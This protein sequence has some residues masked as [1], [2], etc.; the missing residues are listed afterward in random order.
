MM[1]MLSISGVRWI[2]SRY[3]CWNSLIDQAVHFSIWSII[4]TVTT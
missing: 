2:Y 1:M 3:L 4:L